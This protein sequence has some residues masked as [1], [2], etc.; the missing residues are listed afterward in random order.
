MNQN[1]V[2]IMYNCSIHL[3]PPGERVDCS[4]RRE[5]F[6]LFKDA[7]LVSL[8]QNHPLFTYFGEENEIALLVINGIIILL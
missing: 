8:V 4:C 6:T 1:I 5:R 2:V 7:T 3:D